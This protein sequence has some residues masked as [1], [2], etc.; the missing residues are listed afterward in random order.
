MP[1][2]ID[3][4]YVRRYYHYLIIVRRYDYNLIIVA[5]VR[6]K[7]HKKNPRVI[8]AGLQRMRTSEPAD[9]KTWKV[10]VRTNIRTQYTTQLTGWYNI[11]KNM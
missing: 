6:N 3:G 9:A 5:N 2:D 1:S 4:R 10:R 8:S 7:K 11:D